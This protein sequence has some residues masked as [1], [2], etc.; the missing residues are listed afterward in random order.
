[1]DT[2]Q[3]STFILCMD[4]CL[5][6]TMLFEGEHLSPNFTVCLWLWPL[7]SKTNTILFKVNDP[8]TNI[9]VKGQ[10]HFPCGNT[11]VSL[12]IGL[13]FRQDK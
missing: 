6:V 8:N 9:Y 13:Y 11:S 3:L 2:V 10:F 7:Y 5:Q 1:M 12:E 4:V